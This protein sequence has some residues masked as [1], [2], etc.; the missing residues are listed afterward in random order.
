MSHPVE[1]TGTC[2]LC[3]RVYLRSEMARHLRE[4]REQQ[5]RRK[6]RSADL[7][8]PKRSPEPEYFHLEVR[9]TDRPDYW[10]HLEA[11]VRSRLADLDAFLRQIWLECCEHLS[12]FVIG[13]MEY[14]CDEAFEAVHADLYPG[15][16]IPASMRVRL[17]ALLAPGMTFSHEYDFGSTTY[18]TL[19]VIDRYT[20]FGRSR[21]K[22]TLLARNDQPDIRCASCQRR[23]AT[24]ICALCP[25]VD[26]G[27]LCLRCARR[28][29]C[30][31]D[32]LLPVVNSPRAGVCGYTGESARME[33]DEND[34][35]GEFA[36]GG[37]SDGLSAIAAGNGAYLGSSRTV[38]ETEAGEVREVQL[39]RIGDGQASAGYAAPPLAPEEWNE[40]L[41]ML[42]YN[43]AAMDLALKC[44]E[45]L[46]G[47]REIE[48]L[49]DAVRHATRELLR[50]DDLSCPSEPRWLACK[51]LA[52]AYDA[53]DPEVAVK[54]ARSALEV[55][56]HA[57][58]AYIIMAEH[59]RSPSNALEFLEQGVKAGERAIHPDQLER[60]KGQLGSLL[61][62]R[63]YLRARA[64]LAEYL[65]ILNRRE[66]AAQQAEELLRLD[67]LDRAG[68]RSLLLPA[69]L[70]AGDYTR[71]ENLVNAFPQDTSA[72]WT[73][74]KALLLYARQGDGPG[75][76]RAL[77]DAFDAN[78]LVPLLVV[79]SSSRGLAEAA[80]EVADELPDE[81]SHMRV[82]IDEAVHYLTISS[83]SWEQVEGAAEWLLK[84]STKHIKGATR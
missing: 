22:I 50:S 60:Y 27:W 8:A 48:S 82:L 52:E 28:H 19:R 45:Q 68:I 59:A 46:T 72:A 16:R 62:A 36:G 18:L 65:W 84:L 41:S 63:P 12:Q 21:R 79:L 55:Y 38:G 51:L 49:G 42:V 23:R 70:A 75:A 77:R 40:A 7:K 11:P 71:A 44:F 35:T 34:F 73:Y 69:L 76:R 2:R 61:E 83:R 39:A 15:A 25:D 53:S 5:S 10:L 74:S 4:C 26:E 81:F 54:L 13:D 78:P 67:A 29:S 17:D 31:Q 24:V 33:R 3:N 66:E 32:H 14:C 56:P 57:A 58:D 64:R 20:R 47:D 9:G 43:P 37:A 6:Q 30:G 1:S 80:A